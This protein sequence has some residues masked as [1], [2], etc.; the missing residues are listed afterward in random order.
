MP[1]KHTDII[2][3]TH[4][5]LT[6]KNKVWAHS[7]VDLGALIDSQ[8]SDDEERFYLVPDC[9]TNNV[10]FKSNHM[11]VQITSFAFWTKAFRIL[12]ELMACRWPQLCLPI[13]QY[14]Y[15]INKQAGKFLFQQVY[16]YDEKFRHQTAT[17]PFTPWNQID[18][19]LWSREL[20]V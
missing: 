3:S 5:T 8:T 12:T 10:T 13:L 2:I 16:T 4:T 17:N 6:I 7:Y 9:A 15:F 19:H 20:H 1:G 18:N 11:H 14:S